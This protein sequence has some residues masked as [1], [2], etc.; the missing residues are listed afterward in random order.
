MAAEAQM[1][2]FARPVRVTAPHPGL[3][4]L[5]T[6][7][8]HESNIA[9]CLVRE[10][11]DRARGFVRRGGFEL[12]LDQLHA[13]RCRTPLHK[14]VVVWRRPEARRMPKIG[15]KQKVIFFSGCKSWQA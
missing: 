15:A 3:S 1:G 10:S 6:E 8:P 12:L 7:R 2:R 5:G 14:S 13:Q 4:A 9:K 11:V